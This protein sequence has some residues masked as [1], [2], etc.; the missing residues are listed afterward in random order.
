MHSYPKGHDVENWT[1][2]TLPMYI[3]NSLVIGDVHWNRLL[4][5]AK[6][7]GVYA[8]LAFSELSDDRL[9]MAQALISPIGDVLIQR[10]KL[11]PSGSERWFFSDGTIDGLKVVTTSVGRIGLLEC[12][13]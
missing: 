2:T 5:G 4:A 13:E 6:S 12:F 3:N 9:Y 8:A 10:R 7:A 11:R 1:V